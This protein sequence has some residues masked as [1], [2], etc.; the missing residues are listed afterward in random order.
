MQND[1]NAIVKPCPTFE[2]G[3]PLMM[4]NGVCSHKNCVNMQDVLRPNVNEE[5]MWKMYLMQ[6][7]RDQLKIMKMLT[8]NIKQK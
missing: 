3:C 1:K 2:A 8:E 5:E 4:S 7:R 6:M